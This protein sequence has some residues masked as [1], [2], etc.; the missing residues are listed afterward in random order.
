MD[1]ISEKS[2][3]SMKGRMEEMR[4]KLM[5]VVGTLRSTVEDVQTVKE[6]AKEKDKGFV[7]KVNFKLWRKG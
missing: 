6:K 2:A 1:N 7:P 5:D 3:E 4:G